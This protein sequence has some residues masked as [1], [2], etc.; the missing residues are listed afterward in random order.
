MTTS[1]K[2]EIILTRATPE[3][4]EY[5]IRRGRKLRAEFYANLFRRAWRAL[6]A[7]PGAHAP[8]PPGRHRPAH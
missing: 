5:Y 7:R 1:S 8:T 4:V 6:T 3:V 2:N